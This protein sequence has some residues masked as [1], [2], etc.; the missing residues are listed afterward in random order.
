MTLHRHSLLESK[1]DSLLLLGTRRS[2]VVGLGKVRTEIIAR[3]LHK[4]V[5][6]GLPQVA[7]TLLFW[8]FRTPLFL[9][10][11]EELSTRPYHDG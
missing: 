11:I 4:I 9:V 1:A 5:Y 2:M 6:R 3:S 7:H 8:H 10:A